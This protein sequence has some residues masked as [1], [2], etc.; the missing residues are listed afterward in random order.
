MALTH[1]GSLHMTE[2]SVVQSG[3][4]LSEFIQ[5]A[6]I[7]HTML[8]PAVLPHLEPQKCTSIK[9][10][11]VG[12]EAYPLS[13]AQKWCKDR[14]FYNVY[15]PTE[16]TIYTT[17]DLFSPSSQALNLGRPIQNVQCY[18]IND[19]HAL[20]PVGAIGELYIGGPGVARGYQNLPQLT[21][22]RF[23]NNPFGP[24][25]L[26]K[27][28]D[29]VRRLNDGRLRFVT[30]VDGQVKIR[31]F[32]IETGEIEAKLLQQPKVSKAFVTTFGDPKRLVAYTQGQVDKS[33]LKA[34]LPHFMVPSAFVE[35]DDLP[36]T[37]NR[38][39]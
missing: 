20:C 36:L 2:Q 15:G 17:F 29:L 8:T 12:G 1:G 19:A 23:I 6:Q 35:L 25:K 39:N 27:T 18:V 21:R 31:G 5:Q 7:S 11:L 38:K 3:Q 32:R 14:H 30:R 26:Y 9:H 33:A 16:T 28:G 4:L 24:G 10:L 34:A 37:R 22:E 13:S